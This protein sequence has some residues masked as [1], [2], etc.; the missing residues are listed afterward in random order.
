[1]RL[2]G[3]LLLALAACGCSGVSEKRSLVIVTLATTR[4]D[5]IGAFGGTAVPTPNLD[6]LAREGTIALD[7]GFSKAAFAVQEIDA[8]HP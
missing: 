4:A 1:M 7:P 6:R 5:R 2:I 3:V 8:S